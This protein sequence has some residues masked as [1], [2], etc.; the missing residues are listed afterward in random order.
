MIDPAHREGVSKGWRHYLDSINGM[1]TGEA[2]GR[3]A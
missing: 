1:F 3:Q 2:A